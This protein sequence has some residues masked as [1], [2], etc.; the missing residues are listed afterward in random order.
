MAE[1]ITIQAT[2]ENKE[3]LI[4]ARLMEIEKAIKDKFT[5]ETPDDKDYIFLATEDMP[6]GEVIPVLK[7]DCAAMFV[8]APEIY[9]VWKKAYDEFLEN[10]TKGR[11]LF[12][13][14]YGRFRN[15]RNNKK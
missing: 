13:E 3:R 1:D 7:A 12:K 9:E 14:R 8:E 4:A 10:Q 11:F 5:V 15:R 2:G 6:N